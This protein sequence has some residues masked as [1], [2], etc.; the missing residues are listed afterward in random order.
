MLSVCSSQNNPYTRTITENDG[1]AKKI[2]V[3]NEISCSKIDG[4]EEVQILMA[5]DSNMYFDLDTFS[6]LGIG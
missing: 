1:K 5:K 3:E 4:S 2:L 6:I